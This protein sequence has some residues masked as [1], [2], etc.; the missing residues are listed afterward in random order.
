MPANVHTYEEEIKYS[1]AAVPTVIICITIKK[2]N[3]LCAYNYMTEV[4]IYMAFIILSNIRNENY[5]NFI[6]WMLVGRIM[7]KVRLI[8]RNLE[9]PF[10]VQFAAACPHGGDDSHK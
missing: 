9:M 8:L 5:I 2:K 10:S 4:K 6:L 7:Y 1:Q 3:R